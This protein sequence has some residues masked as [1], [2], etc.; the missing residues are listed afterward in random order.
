MNCRISLLTYQLYNVS[1]V[2]AGNHF[3]NPVYSMSS[4][5]FRNENFSGKLNNSQIK[6]NLNVCVKENNLNK[7]LPSLHPDDD[8]LCYGGRCL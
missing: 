4:A 6:N 8:D 5:S 7:Q 1:Y 3:D 2:I